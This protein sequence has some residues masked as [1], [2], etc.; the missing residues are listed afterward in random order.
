MTEIISKVYLEDCISCFEIN[1]V[2]FNDQEER[3]TK[4]KGQFKLQF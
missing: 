1:E 3:F 4:Y 2:Y